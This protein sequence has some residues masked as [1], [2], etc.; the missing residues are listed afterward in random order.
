MCLLHY[1]IFC[2]DLLVEVSFCNLFSHEEL[3][4][5]SSYMIQEVEVSLYSKIASAMVPTVS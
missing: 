1:D 3:F 5:H 4:P 2:I